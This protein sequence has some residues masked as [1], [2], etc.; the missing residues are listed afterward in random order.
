VLLHERHPQPLHFS[1]FLNAFMMYPAKYIP[2]IIMIRK[3][4]IFSA[5]FSSSSE[6]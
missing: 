3:M 2:A 4:N 1:A 5:I 6:L